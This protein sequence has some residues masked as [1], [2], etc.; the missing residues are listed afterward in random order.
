MDVNRISGTSASRLNCDPSLGRQGG[1][2][3]HYCGMWHLIEG[4]CPA[5]DPHSTW[6][7]NSAA[8]ALAARHG[9]KPP[10]RP[11]TVRE[12]AAIAAPAKAIEDGTD[13]A[14][15]EKRRA[16]AREAMRKKRERDKS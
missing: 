8:Q 5:L 4:Y 10:K 11:E 6:H 7:G 1:D 3:C 2:H 14:R 16:A 13:E 15:K 9:A 12:P